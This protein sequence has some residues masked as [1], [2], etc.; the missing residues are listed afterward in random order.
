MFIKYSMGNSWASVMT[1]ECLEMS[2][3]EHDQFSAKIALGV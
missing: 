2:L 1:L 3:I